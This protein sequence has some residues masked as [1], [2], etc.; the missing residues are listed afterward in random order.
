MVR[1]ETHHGLVCANAGIDSG[2]EAVFFA[3]TDGADG[4]AAAFAVEDAAL[5][6][7]ALDG[8]AVG[9]VASPTPRERD[10][11]RPERDGPR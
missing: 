3:V 4:D 5:E 2:L 10:A 6:D 11:P 7:A 1:E 9:E 8:D